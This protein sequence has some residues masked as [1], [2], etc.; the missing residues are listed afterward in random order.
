MQK[1][2]LILGLAVLTLASCN[3]QQKYHS[4]GLH[5]NNRTVVGNATSN[6]ATASAQG[7]Q[8]TELA[9]T[10]SPEKNQILAPEQPTSAQTSSSQTAIKTMQISTPTKQNLPIL[11]QHGIS[12]PI[13]AKLAEMTHPAI[14]SSNT[15]T[16][17]IHH[18]AP[19]MKSKSAMDPQTKKDIAGVGKAIAWILIFM[20]LLIFL[21]QNMLT[22]IGLASLGF[23]LLIIFGSLNS[24]ANYQ[25]KKSGNDYGNSTSSNSG[26]NSNNSTELDI[27]I[28]T[29][30]RVKKGKIMEIVPSGKLKIMVGTD[31]FEYPM[32]SVERIILK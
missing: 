27:V 16:S 15:L 6:K 22:G 1:G 19:A 10:P 29:D 18:V 9:S 30:G 14:A 4:R 3:V 24:A 28:L 11:S 7:F 21:Y 32:T 26:S 17:K 25:L 12:H 8:K 20:A 5:W 31:V 13:V 2:F 23:V